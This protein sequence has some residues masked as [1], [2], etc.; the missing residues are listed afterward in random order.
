[1]GLRPVGLLAF[2]ASPELQDAVKIGVL[3]GSMLSA[4]VG[5]VVLAFAPCEGPQ[6]AVV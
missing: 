3:S 4:A 6:R 5:A 1:M 2:P